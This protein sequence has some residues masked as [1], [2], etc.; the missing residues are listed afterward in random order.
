[1]N[2]DYSCLKGKK[3]AVMDAKVRRCDVIAVDMS[4]NLTSESMEAAE[5]VLIQIITV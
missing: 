2:R 4:Q 5:G 1:M 3:A